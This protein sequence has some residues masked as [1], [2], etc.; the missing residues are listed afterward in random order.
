MCIMPLERR[1]ASNATGKTGVED[2]DEV[3]EDSVGTFHLLFIVHSK[4]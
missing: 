1:G 3:P 2:Q 4:R